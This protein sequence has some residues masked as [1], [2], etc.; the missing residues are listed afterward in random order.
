[1]K[2]FLSTK[3]VKT[4]IQNFCCVF[5]DCKRTIRDLQGAIGKLWIHQS[6][7]LRKNCIF[8]GKPLFFL[9]SPNFPANY[10]HY[11]SCEWKIIPPLG[12]RIYIEFS[13]FDL[14]HSW[15]ISDEE[16]KSS[17]CIFDHLTIEEHDSSDTIV[18]TD[19]HCQSMPKPLNTSNAVVL[20]FVIFSLTC[21]FHS[22]WIFT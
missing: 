19:R 5:L 9:E 14:E 20:K 7:Q 8:N 16:S 3:R 17:S 4:I 2:L 1:M 12:N 18:R 22:F 10:P 15:S 6:N 21:S 13:H 11:A